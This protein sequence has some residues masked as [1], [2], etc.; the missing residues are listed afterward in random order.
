MMWYVIKISD[1][2]RLRYQYF[3]VPPPIPVKVTGLWQ[4]PQKSTKVGLKSAGVGPKSTEVGPES[5]EV[6]GFQ[7]NKTGIHYQGLKGSLE[8]LNSPNLM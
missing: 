5:T 4:S 3:S 2:D 1:Y 6:A 7:C 8:F